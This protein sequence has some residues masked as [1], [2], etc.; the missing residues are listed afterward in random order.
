MTLVRLLVALTAI[1][2]LWAQAATYPGGVVSAL[3]GPYAYVAGPIPRAVDV[4]VKR[5]SAYARITSDF[6]IVEQTLTL[7]NNGDKTSF[8]VGV[9]QATLSRGRN[10]IRTGGPLAARAWLDGAVLNETD[11]R[12][13][14]RVLDDSDGYSV[15]LRITLPK[16]DHVF[17]LAI[18]VQTVSDTSDGDVRRPAGSGW[19]HLAL[20]LPGLGEG[21][22]A[23]EGAPQTIAVE[24]EFD[25][26]IEGDTLTALE[27]TED[28]G[29]SGRRWY[30]QVP[31]AVTLRYG[32]SPP[33]DEG[34]PAAVLASW[35]RA[36]SADELARRARDA[37][38]RPPQGHIVI[39]SDAVALVRPGDTPET[40]N[41]DAERARRALLVPA[42]GLF[43]VVLMLYVLRRRTERRRSVIR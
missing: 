11:I 43:L 42:S 16:G 9:D 17:T 23:D 27:W 30:W 2:P 15:G 38:S 28:A 37:L 40:R 6:V 12:I 32:T 24:L 36:G 19:S 41:E 34:S 3:R 14:D 18:A 22:T 10:P 21:F 13:R 33:P 20:E 7:T 31:P 8:W 35:V 29:A 4:A 25:P 39:A 26:S 5:A 1:L